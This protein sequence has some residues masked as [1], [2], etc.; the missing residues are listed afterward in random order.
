MFFEN[1]KKIRY[2]MEFIFVILLNEKQKRFSA[3][4][5]HIEN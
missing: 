2:V 1:V 5:N 4:I 3:V